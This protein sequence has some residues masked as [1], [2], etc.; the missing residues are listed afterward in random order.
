MYSESGLGKEENV[1][2]WTDTC[3]AISTALSSLCSAARAHPPW[4]RVIRLCRRK[5]VYTGVY[6]RSEGRTASSVS[7]GEDKVDVQIN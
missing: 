4:C 1:M 2:T 5:T 7:F 3:L 6:W